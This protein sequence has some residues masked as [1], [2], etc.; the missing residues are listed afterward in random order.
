MKI[1]K[2][3]HKNI[4]SKDTIRRN[5]IR[6]VLGW[7]SVFL[8]LVG[9]SVAVAVRAASPSWQLIWSDEFDGSS[10]NTANWKAYYSTY[11]DSNK[12]EACLTPNNVTVS[13]GTLQLT[14]KKEQITCPGQP[15]DQFSSAFLGSREAGKYYPKFAK[16]EIRAKLPHG[17]GLWPAFWLRHSSGSSTAEIDIMEYFHAQVP[18]KST[19]T[20]HL[21]G[22]T[23]IAKKT[24]SFEQPTTSPGWHTWAVEILPSSQGS[25][26][27]SFSFS[28]D[29]N[30]YFEI[31]PSQQNWATVGDINKMFDIAINLAVGGNYV[32]HPDDELGWSRYLNKCLKPY[33]STTRPCD[34]SNIIRP[35]FPNSYEIDYV[36]V[37]KQ[38][39]T[40]PVANQSPS[41]SLTSPSDGSKAVS[42]A[43]IKLEANASDSDGSI[44]KVEFYNN[45]TKLGE[46]ST[47]PNPYELNL[48]SLAK[49]EY[50][51]TAKA[52]DDKGATTTS[53]AIT[54]TVEDPV[55]VPP[56]STTTIS[57]PTNLKVSQ[58]DSSS[59]RATWDKSTSNEVDVYSLRYIRSDSSTK[60]DGSTWIYPGRVSSDS[61][62]ITG[63]TE[64]ISYDFQ[65]RAI[66]DKGTDSSSD[67]LRSAY[68]GSTTL[69]LQLSDKTPPS[70]VRGVSYYLVSDFT[71][72]KYNLSLNWKPSL[73]DRSS[74]TY[75]I[76]KQ[77]S[78]GFKLLATQSGTSFTDVGFDTGYTNS[79][80][81]VAKD[82]SGNQTGPTEVKVKAKCYLWFCNL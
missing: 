74:V 47:Q 21:D 20:L 22:K 6:N 63:L 29:G 56:P 77:Y 38:A 46:D 32:G 52:V 54:I 65:V 7:F 26:N 36:R 33:G 43:S 30:K 11:G 15:T 79:Y 10:L 68:T 51:F 76:Y 49:G 62:D 82:S 73:D 28:L 55:V 39:E 16:Y 27:A 17:Q 34:G 70:A 69:A 3:L 19:S 35:Q 78:S 31:I 42:P 23:N 24:V 37:Y 41:V 40:V 1:K 66:D 44:S 13:G 71:R 57:P 53:S 72:W 48:S 12:E 9:I 50:V 18:G 81:I 58:L 61:I 14:A 67:D 80:R 5:K 75:E 60:S 64:G 59:V 4:N 2:S 45:S 25:S 8:L